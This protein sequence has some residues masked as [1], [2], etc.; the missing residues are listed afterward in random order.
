MCC[1]DTLQYRSYECLF[2]II[3]LGSFYF[4]YKIIARF[5]RIDYVNNYSYNY[6]YVNILHGYYFSCLKQ[7]RSRQPLSHKVGRGRP[8]RPR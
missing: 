8:G 6:L 1:N 4:T 2:I 5:Y 7:Q 3:Y